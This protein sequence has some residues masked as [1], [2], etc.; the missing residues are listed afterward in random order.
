MSEG[1]FLPN[2][3]GQTKLLVVKKI[4]ISKLILIRS[5]GFSVHELQK[6]KEE[7][8]GKYTIHLI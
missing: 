7:Q 5:F 6:L 8:Y 4:N 3:K 2:I 1:F